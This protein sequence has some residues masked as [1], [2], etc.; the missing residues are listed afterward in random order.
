MG[1]SSGLIPTVNPTKTVTI[2][3]LGF[4]SRSGLGT[5]LGVG[6]LRGIRRPWPGAS[7]SQPHLRGGDSRDGLKS[8]ARGTR[9]RSIWSGTETA[10]SRTNTRGRERAALSP[11]STRRAPTIRS[12][13]SAK[14]LR[15]PVRGL[16][17]PHVF[18]WWPPGRPPASLPL[19]EVN[20]L[21]GE[22]VA[23]GHVDESNPTVVVPSG[24]GF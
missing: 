6:R 24:P 23:V 8:G 10:R 20:G 21:L 15:G 3:G 7:C 13:H 12:P 18:T 2:A 16:D 4:G 22:P 17:P 5:G 14:G 11:D 19:I 1:L 9:Y